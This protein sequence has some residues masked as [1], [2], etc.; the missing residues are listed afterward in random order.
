M[1]RWAAIMLSLCLLMPAPGCRGKYA[2]GKASDKEI[3]LASEAVQ[4]YLQEVRSVP[5]G[6]AARAPEWLLKAASARVLSVEKLDRRFKVLVELKDGGTATSRYFLVG[7]Q[8]G[9]YKVI[10]II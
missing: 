4:A 2:T 7:E 8:D 1:G 5:D 9:R 10:G 3:R 6:A